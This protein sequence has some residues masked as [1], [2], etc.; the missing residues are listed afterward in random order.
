MAGKYKRIYIGIGTSLIGLFA[1]LT[2]M[3]LQIVDTTGDITCAGTIDD[4][5]VSY[6]EVRNPT[7]RSIYI[8]NY[9]EVQLDFSPDIKGYELYV[10]YYGKWHYT[11]FT[12][13]TRLGN[14]PKD[15]KYSFVFPRYSIK[16]FKLVGYKHNPTDDIKWSV[17]T[18]GAELDP[19]WK[20][21]KDKSYT[22]TTETN[23]NDNG[24]C[25]TALYSG[26]KYVYEDNKWKNVEEA[27]SLKDKGFKVHFIENDTEFPI[28]VID[29]NY[30][31]ITVKL[32]VVDFKDN[33]PVRIWKHNSE[34]ERR[35]LQDILNGKKISKGLA[36]DYKDTHKRIN[37]EL[38]SQEETRT[39]DFSMDSILEFGY[40]STT[41]QLQD[42]N[43]E[44]LEDI[45]VSYGSFPNFKYGIM[46]KFNMSSIVSG[47]SIDASSFNVY[48]FNSAGGLT[49]TDLNIYRVA[50][51]TWTEDDSTASLNTA[52]GTKTDVD[53]TQTISND[54][55]WKS[56]DVTT[57]VTNE[58]A[59]NTNITIGLED[60]DNVITSVQGNDAGTTTHISIGIESNLVQ[61]YSKEHAT[62][63]TRPYLNITYT[64]PL[65]DWTITPNTKHEFD[66][67]N[68]EYNSLVYI[69][70]THYLNTYKG[71][72][73][74][75]YA[76]V[77]TVNA[78]DWTITNG[79]KH[80]FDT[81][82]AYHNSLIQVDSTHYL[83]AYSGLDGDGYAIVLTVNQTDWTITNSSLHEF[84]TVSSYYNSLAQI[85]STHYLNAYGGAGWD[86]HA[87]VLTIDNNTWTVT[88]G[89]KHEFDI[90]VAFYNS[91]VQI[92]STHYLNAYSGTDN[93][94]Y[95]VVLIVNISDWTV[96]SGTKHEFDTDTGQ[97]NSLVQIDSTHYINAYSGADNHGYAVILI[98]DTDAWTVT[99]GVKHEFDTNNSYDN[100]LIQIDSTHYINAYSGKDYDGYAVILTVNQTDW[101][102]TNSTLYEFDTVFG[103]YNSLVQINTSHYI[104]AYSGADNDGYAIVLS[105]EI[106]VDEIS[107]TY[108]DNSTNSTHT[109]QDILHSLNWADEEGLSGYIFS[110]DNGTGSFTNDS[111][112]SMTGTENW[113]NVTKTVNAIGGTT[114]QWKIYANDTSDNWATSDIYTYT[115]SCSDNDDCALCYKCSS[116]VCVVQIDTE[117][118]KSE[119][120]ASYND[121][122]N[123]YTR[124]GPDGLC[125]GAGACDTNDNSVA[126][127][128][129]YVCQN[130]NNINPSGSS[131]CG[132]GDAEDCNCAIWYVCI[133]EACTK[134][135]YYTGFDG[136]SSCVIT[137]W[138]SKG[139]DANVTA[140]V[141]IA[142]T[143][144]V[145]ICTENTA[146]TC[147]LVQCDGNANTPYYHGWDGTFTCFYRNDTIGYCS[148]A[149]TC[150]SHAYSCTN[151]VIDG[152]T[153]VT[154]SLEMFET[155][156][157][158][159]IAGTCSSALD[160]DVEE[161]SGT[162]FYFY[163]SQPVQ[164]EIEPYGQTSAKGMFTLHN[165]YSYI[166][167]IYAK[168]NETNGVTLK[169]DESYSY[170][171]SVPITDS[172]VLIYNNLAIDATEYVWAWADFNNLQSQWNPELDITAVAS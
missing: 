6:F 121:C 69:D 47:S 129:G 12:K 98:V 135:E 82:R 149:G 85:D 23:C 46:V 171:D 24:K 150:D 106:P 172:Y 81:I 90:V 131:D 15:R 105:V 138:Q 43:T 95:A 123:Q 26:I 13:E 39:Y 127:T 31:S 56:F 136:N 143:E 159:T 72:L 20:G 28:E 109:G 41:I 75:G 166:I 168:L 63:A 92:D 78:E 89:T 145:S 49:D 114:I 152:S 50:S 120:T 4:P 161:S 65:E 140:N 17:G 35:F 112:V 33:I 94:G 119:C 125:D 34:L 7:A 101:T 73:E 132:S 53:N 99:S 141:T 55:E 22:R 9:D 163:A 52:W 5:C 10:L 25:W 110:F 118:L 77:L 97:C 96:T 116:E 21:I 142:T 134:P 54:V 151:A 51:Q 160:F 126:V 84:E 38:L 61:F 133:I 68:G 165:N 124:I 130:G 74:D 170:G 158:G 167:D 44:N 70:S 139:T 103:R 104:D 62:V 29:F 58:W 100:S 16:K 32:K 111:W 59:S 157:S 18:N 117:D 2:M 108:S 80:E 155:G 154:C 67:V 30:T 36:K 37:F 14:I 147:G 8:Y 86:G 40:N 88:S 115:T 91:L 48:L 113:S 162:Y 87:V 169:L 153:G 19:M 93:D 3:G 102:I 107:P 27:R 66:D 156:C 71:E 122:S 60:P 83:N 45:T 42:A 137:N 128:S 64:L 1:I 146:N 79:T 144:N 11:N 148:G 76:V 164:T 57:Q